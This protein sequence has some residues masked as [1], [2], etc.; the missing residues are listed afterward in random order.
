MELKTQPRYANALEYER[1]LEKSVAA[2][3]ETSTCSFDCGVWDEEE[4]K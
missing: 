4:I 1:T 2:A 3:G